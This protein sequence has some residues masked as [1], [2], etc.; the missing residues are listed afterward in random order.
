MY[1]TGALALVVFFTCAVATF[2]LARIRYG[3]EWMPLVGTKKYS[4]K[5]A[6]GAVA[7]FQ[8]LG[9][10]TDWQHSASLSSLFLCGGGEHCV[11]YKG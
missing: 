2:L 4:C 10:A 8:R 6:I 5:L 11:K 9:S 1:S 3:T 7:T